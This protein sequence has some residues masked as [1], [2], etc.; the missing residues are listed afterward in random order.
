MRKGCSAKSF[1]LIDLWNASGLPSYQVAGRRVSHPKAST[2]HPPGHNTRAHRYVERVLA[3]GLRDHHTTVARR[4]HG[5]GHA[6]QFVAQHQGHAATFRKRHAF[7]RHG[8][9]GLLH[10]EHVVACGLQVGHGAG[11]I[12]R[13]L[14]RHREGGAQGGLLD[15]AV[16]GQRCEAA[17]RDPLQPEGIGGAEDGAH[18]VAAAHIVEHEPDGSL[19]PCI[20]FGRA[21]TAQFV[22]GELAV[23]GGHGV[24]KL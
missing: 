23:A 5:V 19:G 12:G 7:Q 3:A 1:I 24:R 18:V 14:P 8:L 22:H 13:M 20:M 4:D 15:L 10:R 17:E 11:G 9:H 16:G 6:V 2:G 21:H